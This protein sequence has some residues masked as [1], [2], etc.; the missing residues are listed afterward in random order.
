MSSNLSFKIEKVSILSGFAKTKGDA[1]GIPFC[2][3]GNKRERNAA[4]CCRRSHLSESENP[5]EGS[6]WETA[7]FHSFR[8]PKPK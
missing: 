7:V 8:Q 5:A 2:F 1:S 4:T 6:L 3:G